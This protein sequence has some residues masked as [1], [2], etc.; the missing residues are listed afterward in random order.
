IRSKVLVDVRAAGVPNPLSGMWGDVA[1]LDGLARFAQQTAQLGYEGM[2]VIHPTHVP[3]VNEIFSPTAEDI[4]EW[5]AVIAA[6][7][8]AAADGRGAIRFRG[9][10]IDEA[11]VKTAHQGLARARAFGLVD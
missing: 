2:M 4:E 7:D 10:L 3:V 8:D 6:M 9:Q 11:H 5:S 1:D